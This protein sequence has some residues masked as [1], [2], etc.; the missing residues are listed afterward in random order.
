MISIFQYTLK[1]LNKDGSVQKSENKE[2][3]DDDVDVKQKG[4]HSVIRFCV[5][6]DK[7]RELGQDGVID[8]DPAADATLGDVD[9]T[10]GGD[11]S[12]DYNPDTDDIFDFFSGASETRSS[13]LIGV[14][15][16]FVIAKFV[17]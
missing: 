13:F 3:P 4:P 15:S 6:A 2:A 7:I 12:A 5:P 8:T 16:V 17:L 1:V 10:S 14:L 9:D 11:P